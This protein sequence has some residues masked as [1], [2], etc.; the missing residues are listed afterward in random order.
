MGA[1]ATKNNKEV[2]FVQTAQ[3]IQDLDRQAKNNDDDFVSFNNITTNAVN[4]ACQ[5]QAKTVEIGDLDPQGKAAP[6]R[7]RRQGAFRKKQRASK[8]MSAKRKSAV[9]TIGSK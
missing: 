4:A 6:E 3:V 9:K 7:R 8:K 1:C 5:I 2:D